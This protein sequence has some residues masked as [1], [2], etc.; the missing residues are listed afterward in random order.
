MKDL[1]GN[2]I[3]LGPVTPEEANLLTAITR[4]IAAKNV[5]EFGYY[6][7]TSAKAFLDGM[8]E[9]GKVISIDIL[10]RSE[11]RLNDQRLNLIKAD[12]TNFDTTILPTFVDI[13]FFDASHSLEDNIAAFRRIPNKYKGQLIIVHDTGFWDTNNYTDIPLNLPKGIVSH[14]PEEQQFIVWLK[15]FGY[16][17]ITF[18]TTKEFRCGLTVLQ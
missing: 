11:H 16:E 9:D 18:S 5:L 1:Q 2:E 4:M 13:I 8:K 17:A 6:N 7:G 10:D 3:N 14:R 15:E 12:M